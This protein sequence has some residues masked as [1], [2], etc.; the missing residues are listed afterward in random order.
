MLKRAKFFLFLIVVLVG[1]SFYLYFQY[2]RP[3]RIDTVLRSP[4]PLGIRLL[5]ADEKN[6]TLE[7]LGQMV[8]YPAQGHIFFYFLNTDARYPQGS[9]PIQQLAIEQ[10][11]RF[12]ELTGIVN[13]YYI[14]LN[15]AD[16]PRLLN[17]MEGMRVFLEQPLALE[18]AR[19]QYPEGVQF[20]PGEQV[21]EYFLARQPM[22]RGREHLS[23]VDRLLRMESVLLN[24]FWQRAHYQQLLQ[25]NALQALL[26]SLVSTNLTGPELE[27]LMD[28]LVDNEEFYASVMEAPLREIVLNNKKALEIKVSRAKESFATFQGELA[29]GRVHRDNFSINI[30]NGTQIS[31]LARKVQ[32]LLGAGEITV[33]DTANYPF[34]PVSQS[35]ILE[36]SGNTFFGEKMLQRLSFDRNRVFFQRQLL[37]VDM[38]LILGTDYKKSIID[39]L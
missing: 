20:F 28:F 23:G 1:G 4:A 29:A 19:F 14:H 18:G 36:R 21:L 30:L 38:T 33:L 35:V 26:S 25:H 32:T 5:L 16:I 15:K 39:A 37:D 12:F 9:Q 6:K 7:M 31:R 24:L 10:A 17:I 8:L 3:N 13:E 11:D 27:S 34:K 2:F 22:E